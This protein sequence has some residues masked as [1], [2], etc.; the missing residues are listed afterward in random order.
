MLIET[1]A[2]VISNSTL[3]VA[4]AKGVK[5]AKLAWLES[6]KIHALQRQ[7]Q[8]GAL[9]WADAHCISGVFEFRCE[10]KGSQTHDKWF[11]LDKAKLGKG[12]AKLA[13]SNPEEFGRIASGKGRVED[14]IILLQLALFGRERF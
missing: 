3:A 13:T 10:I 6:I 7:P 9:A 2:L 1:N 11:I 14:C 8:A 5:Y 12:L 4:L